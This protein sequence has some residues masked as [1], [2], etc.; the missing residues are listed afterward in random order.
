MK[1]AIIQH[2]EFNTYRVV[3]VPEGEGWRSIDE[4]GWL[5][6][7]KDFTCNWHLVQFADIEG[8]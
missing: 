8:E 4:R 1:V 2:N 7:I 5:R 6:K 3:K